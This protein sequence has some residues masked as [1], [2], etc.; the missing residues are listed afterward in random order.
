MASRGFS[1]LR[2][3]LLPSHS[4]VN[5]RRSTVFFFFSSHQHS[6]SF[7]AAAQKPTAAAGSE[8][9]GGEEA[10]KKKRRSKKKN[11]IEV[12]QFLPNWGVGAK[13]TKS[14]WP[15]GNFYR[16]TNVKLYKSGRH[17]AAWGIFHQSEAPKTD[18]AQKIGG[19][20]KRCWRYVPEGAQTAWKRIVT[21]AAAS[22]PAVSSASPAPDTPATE[23]SAS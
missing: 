10:V 13:F 12:A 11:F 19:V 6:R 21:F 5:Q 2:S 22:S 1:K 4:Q 9:Q 16:V 7:A 8:A 17:G 14:H 3:A 18:E 20:N 15:E 23:V